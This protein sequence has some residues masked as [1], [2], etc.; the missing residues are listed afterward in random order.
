MYRPPDWDNYYFRCIP[1]V[2]FE[3]VVKKPETIEDY[4]TFGK[5]YGAG[6]YAMLEALRKQGIPG[7]MMELQPDGELKRIKGIKVFIPD[8]EE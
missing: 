1:P 3:I 4:Y 6:A 5:V 2:E 8:E 7:E